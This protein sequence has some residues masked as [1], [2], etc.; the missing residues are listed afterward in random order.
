MRRNTRTF[1]VFVGALGF[2]LCASGLPGEL[3]AQRS[4]ARRGAAAAVAQEEAQAPAVV[5]PSESRLHPG[6]LVKDFEGLPFR[7]DEAAVT[8]Y[9]Q[10]RLEEIY[11]PRILGTPDVR[12]RDLLQVEKQERVAEFVA[13]QLAFDGQATGF[14]ASVLADEFA[15]GRGHAL[16]TRRDG[17]VTSRFFFAKGE[18]WKVLQQIPSSRESFESLAQQFEAAYGPPAR[19]ESHMVRG[20]GGY[21][22]QPRQLTWSDG[23][24]TVSLTDQS[25]LARSYVARWSVAAIDEREGPL[26]SSHRPGARARFH[27]HEV[28]EQVSG[29]DDDRPETY[30]YVVDLYRAAKRPRAP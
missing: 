27:T 20:P 22:E 15:H 19:R 21:A 5:D 17:D 30:L 1:G 24:L 14:D 28:L 12:R 10:Q 13:T 7:G 9:E 3:S 18:L 16:R 4:R 23:A 25:R 2:V 11:R 6:R 29:S 26:G 8:A